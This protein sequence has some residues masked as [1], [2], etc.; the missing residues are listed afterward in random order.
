MDAPLLSPDQAQ[1]QQQGA[2]DHRYIEEL[3]H[4]AETAGRVA[5][6]GRVLGIAYIIA[7]PFLLAAGVLS[8]M[9]FDSPV[10]STLD[11]VLRWT[12][13]AL[14]MIALPLSTAA[15]GCILTFSNS[16]R[17]AAPRRVPVAIWPVL[18]ISAI[19]LLFAVHDVLVPQL[20]RAARRLLA[21]TAPC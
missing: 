18:V 3:R 16:I 4:A 2:H 20:L 15:A 1:Q 19:L 10:R 7:S 8:V 9:V 13:V 5:G 12:L 6:P 21:K 11:Q 17:A 14:T